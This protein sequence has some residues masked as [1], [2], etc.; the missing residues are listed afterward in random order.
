MQTY[1]PPI[2]D[3]GFL[4]REVLGFDAAMAEL[5]LEVDA[6]LASAVLEEAGK[7][8]AER[9]APLN[10]EGDEQGSRLVDGV[11]VTPL[12]FADAYR[13][14][15]AAGWP[16]LAGDPAHGGQGLPFLLQLWLD[17][18]LS[19]ANLSF[20]LFPGLTRGAA[21]AIAAHGS[22][23]L[24]ATYLEPLVTGQWTGAMALT[25]SS[26][27]TD[28]ALL[29]TKA[30]PLG[31]GSFAVT[32]QKIFISSGDHDM[33]DNIVHLVLARLPDAPPGVKG[34][35]LF[36]V[37]KI[38]PDG[39]R[40]TLSVGALEKKMG[41][42]AQPTC[43]MHYDGAVGWI[44][45]EPNRGLAAMF[46][47]MNAERLM[48]GIQGLGIAGAAYGQAAAYAKDR[49]QGRSADGAT[50]PV[51]II[52]HA[53]VRRMLLN[54]RVFVEAGRALAGWT[55][56]QLDRAKHHSDAGERAKADAMVALLTPVVKAAFT[57]FGFESAVQAQQVLGG[58]GYIRE[59]GMEQYVRDARIAQIY[60]GTNGVQAMDLVG[61]KLPLGGGA[62]VEGFFALIDADLD[63]AGDAG[64]V[65]AQTRVALALL[66]DV[67]AGLRGA[68]V[69][70]TGA[71]AVDYLRLFALVSFGWM[72]ARMAAAPGD[73]ALHQSKR[74]LADYYAARV[75]PQAHGLAAQVQAGAGAMMALEA[76]AF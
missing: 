4:M 15:V 59:W 49:L 46:T 44:V 13:E 16:A 69:E 63:A 48:V 66:R 74:Q 21:E 30:E 71:A 50:G 3:Y 27:G 23:A 56:L 1:S 33:A 68:G 54:I 38:L 70:E 8:C 39:A 73:S 6:D 55:A 52:D 42:H 62:V 7:L 11:V 47:M 43:V 61:R 65:V 60:E 57:D 53:D 51:A 18:M 75:L 20:G 22:D 40:N 9:L 72:W 29:K 64:A 35:S 19:A 58:H 5:G 24:K 34:I 14:F 41:I 76:G 31:D 37:P 28:L 36:L 17:E 2:E 26:A 12:G 67:T 25:E 45:G 32:G 10:R